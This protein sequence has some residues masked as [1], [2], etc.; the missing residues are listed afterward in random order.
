MS[1]SG[2]DFRIPPQ[3]VTIIAPTEIPRQSDHSNTINVL[4]ISVH[5]DVDVDVDVWFSGGGNAVFA[6]EG[7][8][9]HGRGNGRLRNSK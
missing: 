2:F 6:L 8:G 4:Y 1:A 3:S 7:I 9:G 5:V